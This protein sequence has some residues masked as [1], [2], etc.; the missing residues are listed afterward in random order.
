MLTNVEAAAPFFEIEKKTR[1]TTAAIKAQF[2]KKKK[3][4]HS[5][6]V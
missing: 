4:V 6:K 5:V 1:N 2:L 3:A